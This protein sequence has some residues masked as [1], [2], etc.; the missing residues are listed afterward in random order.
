MSNRRRLRP[1]LRRA[2]ADPAGI[3]GPA[4]PGSQ[5]AEQRRRVMVKGFAGSVLMIGGL[6]FHQVAADH[7]AKIIPGPSGPARYVRDVGWLP[8]DAPDSPHPPDPDGPG[9]SPGAGMAATGTAPTTWR[10]MG[11]LSASWPAAGPT[12]TMVW[13]NSVQGIPAPRFGW[14]A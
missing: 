1:P 10:G 5:A 11:E 13:P 14:E 7:S 9:F 8:P 3:P 2:A 6:V 12:P 4:L